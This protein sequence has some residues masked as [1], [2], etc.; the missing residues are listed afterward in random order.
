MEIV[1]P[2]A[3]SLGAAGSTQAHPEV[4]AEYLEMAQV[5]GWPKRV[6]NMKE[7]GVQ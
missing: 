5:G 1:A 7:L 6:G 4:T 3:G 2:H